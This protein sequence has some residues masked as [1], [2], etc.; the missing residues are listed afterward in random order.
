VAAPKGASSGAIFVMQDKSSHY[1]LLEMRK[2]F[3]ANASHELK[4][5]ITIIRGFAEAL[6]DNPD[7][8]PETTED[9][10]AKIVKNCQRMTNLIKDLLTLSDI[11]NIPHSRLI[12][13]DLHEI[14]EGCCNTLHEIFPTA[15]FNIHQQP[16][17]DSYLVA[18]P[19]LMELAMM[20]LIENAAKYSKPPAIIDISLE[21]IGDNITVTIADQGIGIPPADLEHIFERFYTVDKA[22]SQKLGGSGLGLSIVQTIIHKHFGKISV[23]S[24]VGKGTTFTIVLP[25]HQETT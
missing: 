9:V 18:D 22:H 5:P 2:E 17:I 7:L 21:T 23:Q 6:H 19:S 20:N 1:K 8:P 12:E 13:C 4:T 25:S 3:I 24:E 10:T 15:Q 14:I 11:E 16:N